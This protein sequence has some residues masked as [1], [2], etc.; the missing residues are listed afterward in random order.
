MQHLQLTNTGGLLA[1]R[2]ARPKA[3]ALNSELVAELREAI[4]TAAADSS[5]RGAILASA[6]PGIFSAGFDARE[7]FPCGAAEIKT[8]FGNFT[9]LCHAMLDFPKPLGAAVEG[10]A[11]AGGAIL[12]LTGDVRIFAEGDYGFALNEINLGLVLSQGILQMAVAAMGA[13]A[14]R[15]LVL[16]GVTM[17]P[18]RAHESG[19][20][21]ELA[22]AGT[23]F[24][25]AEA[26]VRNLMDKPP[27]AFAAVKRLCRETMILP[28]ERELESLD[29]FVRH[30]M[31][32]ESTER[33]QRLAASLRR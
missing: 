23:V 32:D 6:V 2:M 21:A 18:R 29:V 33:R 24:E 22:P 11:M 25:R 15:E 27:I 28:V 5:V 31:S 1:I 8:F 7:I 3:N 19:L 30:W 14:A 10:H 12:A 26:R 20:A 17:N 13:A 16:D 9:V 4:G